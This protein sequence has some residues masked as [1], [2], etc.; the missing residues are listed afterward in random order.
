MIDENQQQKTQVFKRIKFSEAVNSIFHVNYLCIT[1]RA[2]RTEYWYGQL[3][4]L[5]IIVPFILLWVFQGYL[6]FE[7]TCNRRFELEFFLYDYFVSFL[8]FFSL[9]IPNTILSIRRLHDSNKSAWLILFEYIPLI[10]LIFTIIFGL[11]PSV[12]ANNKYF[13]D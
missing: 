3:C 13:K 10:G 12:L 7:S 8:G 1:Q 5:L 11:M 4:F 9:A 6:N 2:S